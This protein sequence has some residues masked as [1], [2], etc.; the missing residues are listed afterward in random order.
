MMEAVSFSE[1]SDTIIY[2]TTRFTI[3]ENSRAIDYNFAASKF[4]FVK[5]FLSMNTI[6]L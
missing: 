2:Q 3:T 1:T 5:L 4:G 6:G